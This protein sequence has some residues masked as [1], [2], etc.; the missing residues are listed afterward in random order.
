MS[1]LLKI[2]IVLICLPFFLYSQ[3]YSA[4]LIKIITKDDINRNL[5]VP[6]F[7]RFNFNTNRLMLLDAPKGRIILYNENF[8]PIFSIGI[9]RGLKKPI[10][11]DYFKNEIYVLEQKNINENYPKIDIFSTAWRKKREIIIKGFDN[12]SNFYPNSIAI[13]K[14]NGKIY[15]SGSGIDGIV[16]LNNKGQFLK[17]ISIKDRFL[18]KEK[19]KIKVSFSDLY[20]DENQR[21]Y[22]LSE[23]LGRVYVFSKYDI[24]QFKASQKG[25]TRGK[26]SRPRG[27]VASTKL[28]MIFVVDY[29]RQIVQCLDYKDGKFLFEFGGYGT[30][31][32]NFNY[33]LKITID[34]NNFLYVTDMFNQRVQVFQIIKNQP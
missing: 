16:V 9:G 33:P 3:N 6:T 34:E 24:L 21:V 14:K 18:K 22:A 17:K 19:E 27:V 4:K 20:I 15:L 28:K 32:G 13:N 29:L 2:F 26:L 10:A 25:G 31:P 5:K 7:I 30:F 8:F 1:Q 23:K 12:D 11:F